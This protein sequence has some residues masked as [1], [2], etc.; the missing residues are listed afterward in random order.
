M[1]TN[2]LALLLLPALAWGQP[3]DSLRKKRLTALVISGAAAYTV[4]IAGLSQLWYKDHE[5]QPFTFFNDIHEWKQVDKAGHLYSSYQFSLITARALRWSGVKPPKNERIGALTGFLMMLPIEILDGFS[6]GY[7]ASAWDLAFN[8]AGAGLYLGQAHW[9]K[10]PRLHPKFS[11]H[12]TDYAPVRPDVLGDTFLSE[13]IKDYNGQ[14]YW[15]SADMD[16]FIRFPRWLNLAAGYGAEDMVY[17]DDQSNQAAG[18]DPHRQ[19]YLGLDFDLTAIQSRSKALRTALF[20]LNMIRL[21][22]PA[23]EFSRKGVK[24]YALYF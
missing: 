3:P 23:V 12:R 14:T 21:P 1:R 19:Y 20:F 17:A 18:Y 15:L 6:E 8:A 5:K 7:G 16:T 4:T 22:A 9:W 24:V 2:L 10:R 13:M 11:F